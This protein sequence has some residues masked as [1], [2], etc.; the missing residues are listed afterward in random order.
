MQS[1]L[2]VVESNGIVCV[3]LV[4]YK[5]IGTKSNNGTGI[6]VKADFLQPLSSSYLFCLGFKLCCGALPQA[7][8]TSP[9]C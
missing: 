6:Q 3:P 1:D 9:H 5:A 4:K 7:S 8:V 2:R